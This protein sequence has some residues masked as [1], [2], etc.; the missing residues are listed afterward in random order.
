MKQIILSVLLITGCIAN[1][2]AQENVVVTQKPGT[3]EYSPVT[4]WSIGIKGGGNYFRVAPL[5]NSRSDQFHL[6]FGGTVEYTINPLVGIGL[7]YNY[8]DYSRPYNIPT[9]G[10]LNGGTHDAILYN[11]FNLSNILFPLRKGCWSKMNIYGDAGVGLAFYHFDLDHGNSTSDNLSTAPISGMAKIGLNAEY[12][13]SKSL[14]LGV[15]GQFRYYDRTAMGGMDIPKGNCDAVVAS[16][17]LRYKF[18]A[19]GIKKHARNISMCEYYPRPTPVIINRKIV[20]GNTE[21]TL[22]RMKMM[23]EENAIQKQKLQKLED[24]LKRLAAQKEGVVN[25]SFQNIEFEFGLSRLTKASLPTLDQIAVI[26]KSN[27]D[28]TRLKVSG[29]AD[30]IGATDFNQTLS[31]NRANAVK[32]YLRS[33]G[34]PA[35]SVTTIGYGETKPIDTNNTPEGRQNN[36]RVEFEITKI[37]K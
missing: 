1:A 32:R 33:K 19:N 23:E 31:E 13:I 37:S 14:A 5:S 30:S 11:S 20:D 12:N 4:H 6:M 36:R 35:S 29:H 16:V 18:A 8:N 10:D 26:L 34:V 17:G 7:E 2:S 3:C 9:N 25:A 28:W 24:D 21:E 22:N 27:P 15:E